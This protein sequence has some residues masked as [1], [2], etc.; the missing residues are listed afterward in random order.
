MLLRNESKVIH[1]IQI[2]LVF[3]DNTTRELEIHEGECVQMSYRR[4]GCIRCG[5]GIIRR[6]EPYIK[7]YCY[8]KPI[9]SALI[10]L[11]MS[12]ENQ[13]CIDKIELDD[14]IDIR[15]IYSC[16]CPNDETPTKPEKPCESNCQCENTQYS[17][18]VGSVVTNKGVVA[19]G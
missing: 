12:E 1:S 6:I 15:F 3:D 7:K 16:D 9:E 4:N 10:L 14:I 19:H 8:N 5:M 11:D 13:S 17:C 2:K 18:L